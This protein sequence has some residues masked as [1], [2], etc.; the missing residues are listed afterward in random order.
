MFPWVLYCNWAPVSLPVL[1]RATAV[2]Y[3]K[4]GLEW[5]QPAGPG[6]VGAPPKKVTTVP[7]IY[8]QIYVLRSTV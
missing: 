6:P 2:Y 7:S 8:Q 1:G 3:R 4:M 5:G